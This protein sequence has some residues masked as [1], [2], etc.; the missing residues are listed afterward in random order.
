[1][2]VELR[3]ML[4]FVTAAELGNFT[5]AA[6]RLY[7]SQSALSQ[8]IKRLENELGV[9]LFR[10]ENNTVSLTRAGRIFLPEADS[11]LQRSRLLRER[12]TELAGDGAEQLNFGISTFYSR[13]FLP[14][15]ADC[16]R[17]SYPLL[18]VNFIED[19]SANL[20]NMVAS[21][22][23][24]C[25]LAPL[26]ATHDE[27]QITPVRTETI[28]LAL[29][30]GHRLLDEY[31]PDAP[32][33]LERVAREKFVFLKPSQRFTALG[34]RLCADAGF[35]PDIIYETMNWDTLDALVARG[36]GIGFVPDIL[37]FHPSDNKPGYRP[38]ASPDAKR[39]YTLL[40]RPGCAFTPMVKSFLA[41]IPSLISHG[42]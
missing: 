9:E 20:E 36:I 40:N 34:M 22:I 37:T 29:T 28:Y 41:E 24:D 10:R 33:Q 13:Y 14:D 25:C 8:S 32:I 21:G 18:R 3:N 30:R 23:L 19:V 5:K 6:E 12:M 1:M 35:A 2:R 26:P 27:L 15:I 7:I 17:N 39:G 11:I 38:I 31:P 4:C 16:I 42:R